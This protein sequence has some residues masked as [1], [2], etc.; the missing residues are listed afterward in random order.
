MVLDHY[1][2]TAN[3][4]ALR[5]Y[6]P[7]ATGVVEFFWHHYPKRTAE[8]HRFQIWPAQALEAYWCPLPVR[9]EECSVDDAPTLASLHAILPRLLDLPTA[10]TTKP[11]RLFWKTFLDM[12]PPLPTKPCPLRTNMTGENQP[13]CSSPGRTIL[14]PCRTCSKLTD[15]QETPEL[16]SVHPFQIITAGRAALDKSVQTRNQLE[17]AVASYHAAPLAHFNASNPFVSNIGWQQGII[18]AALLGLAN[19]AMAMA[20]Q[21]AFLPPAP[22]ARWQGFAQHLQDSDPSADHFAN[23][24]SAVNLMLI[25]PAHDGLINGSIVLLPSWPCEWSVA[26]KLQGPLRTTIEL[27]W[28]GATK[29]LVKLEVLP[30]HRKSVV[31]FARCV[32]M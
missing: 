10:F 28:D 3:K 16:Y 13:A 18:N 1:L 24:N 11:D 30:P 14:A 9:P 29:K 25:Q 19:D 17:L 4:T 8:G 15:L 26:F 6:L 2:Y 22:G 32:K 31:H 12:L 7:L 27:S 5:R 21:R 20:L 23:M